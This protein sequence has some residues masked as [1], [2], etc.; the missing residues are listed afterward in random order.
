M[1]SSR[2]RSKMLLSVRQSSRL[3][4][5]V[6]FISFAM[7]AITMAAAQNLA[8]SSTTPKLV[9]GALAAAANPLSNC[10]NVKSLFESQGISGADIPTQPITGKYLNCPKNSMRHQIY[11]VNKWNYPIFRAYR[12]Y[13]FGQQ[14]FGIF[15]FHFY[16]PCKCAYISFC[17][18]SLEM[19]MR[20]VHFTLASSLYY[21]CCAMCCMLCVCRCQNAMK[22]RMRAMHTR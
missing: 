5:I 14:F 1:W 7:Q 22:R 8:L 19:M 15:E 6:V 21:V 2:N 13:K 18:H 11:Y 20:S 17:L 3:A 16:V 4:V 10:T 12:P 9:N